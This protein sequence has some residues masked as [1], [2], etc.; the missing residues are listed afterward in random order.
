MLREQVLAV[1]LARALG[2]AG[3]DAAAPHAQPQVLAR[4][5]ALPLVLAREGGAAAREVEDARVGARRVVRRGRVAREGGGR[6][7]EGAGGAGYREGR[8]RGAGG[9]GFGGLGGLCG[10]GGRWVGAPGGTAETARSR[11]WTPRRVVGCVGFGVVGVLRQGVDVGVDVDVGVPGEVVLRLHDADVSALR[12]RLRRQRCLVLQDDAR[13]AVA[14][15]PEVPAVPPLHGDAVLVVRGLG[16][17]NPGLSVR[18]SLVVVVEL[19][20]LRVRHALHLGH[21]DVPH[22]HG[23]LL[24]L[25]LLR[26]HQLRLVAEVATVCRHGAREGVAAVRCRAEEAVV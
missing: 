15:V 19:D 20:L 22:H 26:P 5:V 2:G 10:C 16:L 18:V 3:A 7:G 25:L 13:V 23:G 6:E 4:H 1:E 11:A 24:L 8:A 12:L 21:V 9:F 17:R 14:R